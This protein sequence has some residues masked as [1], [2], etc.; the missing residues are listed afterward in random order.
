MCLTDAMDIGIYYK[1]ISHTPLYINKMKV[2][3]IHSKENKRK[4][5]LKNDAEQLDLYYVMLIHYD[6]YS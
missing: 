6:T 4:Y 5:S 2:N 3:K 1:K